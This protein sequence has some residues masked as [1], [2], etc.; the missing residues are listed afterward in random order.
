MEKKRL[1]YLILLVLLLP[2]TYA[3][4]KSL[5]YSETVYHET[6]V[7]ITEEEFTFN[8]I[9]IERIFIDLPSGSGLTIR[10]ESCEL[11]EDYDICVNNT[12][13]WYHDGIL[14]QDF[15][16][17][18]VKVYQFLQDRANLNL[19]REITNTPVLIGDQTTINVNIKNIGNNKA[20][21]IIYQDP[22][23]SVFLITQVYGCTLEKTNATHH[24]MIWR[25]TLNKNQEK[26]CSYT[27]LA[28]NQTTFESKASLRYDNQVE[29]ITNESKTKT[30]EVPEYQ[31]RIG[32]EI[33]DYMLKT[34]KDFTIGITLTNLNNDSEIRVQSFSVTIPSKL[35]IR[36]YSKKLLKSNRQLSLNDVL[37]PNTSIELN[38][39]L[40]SNVMDDFT[41]NP[42]AKYSINRIVK[43]NEKKI[44][45]EIKGDKLYLIPKIVKT[46]ANQDKANLTIEIRNPSSLSSFQNIIITIKSS[47]PSLNNITR[48]LNELKPSESKFELVF[49]TTQEVTKDTNY[50]LNIT[51]SYTSQNDQQLSTT[52]QQVIKVIG[53]QQEQ[54]ENIPADVEEINQPTKIEEEINQSTKIMEVVEQILDEKIKPKKN[55]YYLIIGIL[56]VLLISSAI[57]IINK[58]RYG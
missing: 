25:G 24:T 49:F 41:L 11:I 38:I 47:L 45:L 14:D 5:V 48:N 4:D 2:P 42:K 36:S 23:P 3:K 34:N 35:E 50:S 43:E 9:S 26:S 20:T 19:T 39:T 28:Q 13:L 51:L 58:I 16:Q 53:K 12:G 21:G 54:K 22:I 29:I 6:K 7:N 31:L 46:V 27:L 15:Y 52:K 55:E 17:A 44:N 10:N 56:A 8:L 37:Q 32:Y 1:F 33:Y 57:I 40:K 18:S 30:I